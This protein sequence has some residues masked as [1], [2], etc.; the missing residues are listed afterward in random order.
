MKKVFLLLPMIFLFLCGALTTSAC[1]YSPQ[2]GKKFDNTETMENKTN[3]RSN[4]AE[5]PDK[6]IRFP[7]GKYSF[8]VNDLQVQVVSLEQNERNLRIGLK[9][10]N[11]SGGQGIKI[12]SFPI[13]VSDSSGG[14]W[15]KVSMTPTDKLGGI[16]LGDNPLVFEFSFA[17]ENIDNMSDITSFSVQID[18]MLYWLVNDEGKSWKFFYGA[19]HLS[20]IPAALS[21]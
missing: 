5:K 8:P 4:K 11:N 15:K 10:I 1:V 3:A 9:F 21:Q 7:E 17:R 19:G 6:K 13:K 20:K 18:R 12:M 14:S 2:S 16:L